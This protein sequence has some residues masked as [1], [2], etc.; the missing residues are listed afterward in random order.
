MC[1]RIKPSALAPRVL[2]RLQKLEDLELATPSRK[3]G[4]SLIKERETRIKFCGIIQRVGVL[5][6]L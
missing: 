2:M 4:I 1:K 3:D 6:D 5:L